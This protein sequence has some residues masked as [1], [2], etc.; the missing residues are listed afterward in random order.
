[1]GRR[2]KALL[3]KL[4]P[5]LYPDHHCASRANPAIEHRR[6]F[7]IRL[8][9]SYVVIYSRKAV[10]VFIHGHHRRIHRFL[11]WGFGDFAAQ[12]AVRKIGS[13]EVLFFSGLADA[14]LLYPFVHNNIGS[15]F[16]TVIRLA[17]SSVQ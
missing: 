4:H 3:R 11:A 16:R 8:Y 9:D 13:L 15:F 12:R 1:M 10:Y 2:R 17:S 14:V 5:L 7:F 6:G